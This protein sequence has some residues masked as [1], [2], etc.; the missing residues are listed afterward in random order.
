MKL[1]N[2]YCVSNYLAV[3]FNKEN[4]RLLKLNSFKNVVLYASTKL[5][6]IMT[7]INHGF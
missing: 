4:L 6:W 3:V 5:N 2:E 1:T 7:E